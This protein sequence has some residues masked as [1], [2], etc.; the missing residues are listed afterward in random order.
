MEPLSLTASA[1]ASLI[2]SKALEKGGEQLGKGISDQIAQLYNLIRDK[3]HK[4]G[5]EGKFTKV[6]EDPSQKNKNRFER[7]LAEQMEDDE[8]FSKKL[9]ALMHELKSDEQ[10]KHIFFKGNKIKGDAE[11]GDVE[12]IT[13]RGGS[14]TEEAVTEVEVGGNFKI[15]E[16]KQQS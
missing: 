16:V 4:E 11:I 10:I 1:I 3:F 7:E 15:G 5:V 13:T 8:A 2:F 12:Q 6:Q 14:V 9:K